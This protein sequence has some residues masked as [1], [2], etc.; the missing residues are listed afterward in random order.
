MTFI[1]GREPAQMGAIGRRLRIVLM[2]QKQMFYLGEEGSVSGTVS[3]EHV[4]LEVDDEGNCKIVNIKPENVT[5]VN[6]MEVMEKKVTKAD[7]IELGSDKFEIKLSAVL[8][9]VESVLVKTYSISHLEAVWKK[10]KADAEALQIRKAKDGVS[11]TIPSLLTTASV[12]CGVLPFIPVIVR[13]VLVCL[14][15][16]LSIYF[17]V[18]RRKNINRDLQETKELQEHLRN[19]YKCP[20]CGRFMGNIDYQDLRLQKGC[21]VCHCKYKE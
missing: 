20:H 17:F 9:A 16:A 12:V 14:G 5:Y 15:L 2:P 10:Y 3:R 8:K 13:A 4:K 21:P 18:K 7:K 11:A 1:I 19:Q 6:G